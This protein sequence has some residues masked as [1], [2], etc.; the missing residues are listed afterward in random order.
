MAATTAVAQRPV[1]CAGVN[2][3]SSTMCT[4]STTTLHGSLD[5]TATED[6]GHLAPSPLLPPPPHEALIVELQPAHHRVCRQPQLVADGAGDLGVW[7]VLV[8]LLS[9]CLVVLET[10]PLCYQQ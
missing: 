10:P 3:L 2:P 7:A 1:G 4:I 8:A 6:D 9:Y 5:L